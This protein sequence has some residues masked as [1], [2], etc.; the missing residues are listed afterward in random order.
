MTPAIY[1]PGDNAVAIYSYIGDINSIGTNYPYS[2]F[3]VRPV[4]NLKSDVKITGGIGTSNYPYVIDT[5]N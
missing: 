5:N 3:G 4:V 1:Y 2:V